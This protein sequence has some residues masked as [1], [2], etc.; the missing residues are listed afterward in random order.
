MKVTVKGHKLVQTKA[1]SKLQTHTRERGSMIL[2][3]VRPG[4]V[5][6]MSFSVRNRLPQSEH[7]NS[8]KQIYIDIGNK[9]DC[10]LENTADNCKNL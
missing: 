1:N 6:Y 3:G 4:L 2:T 7:R 10:A 9:H 5:I 8:S